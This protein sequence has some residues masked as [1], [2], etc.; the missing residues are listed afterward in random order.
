[1]TLWLKEFIAIKCA[2]KLG[3]FRVTNDIYKIRHGS[4]KEVKKNENSDET[5]YDVKK[6]MEPLPTNWSVLF[7]YKRTCIRVMRKSSREFRNNTVIEIFTITAYGTRNKQL[8]VEMIDEA[9]RMAENKPEKKVKYYQTML[10]YG[11]GAWRLVRRA[12]PRALSSVVLREGVTKAIEE[13][14]ADFLVNKQW[15]SQRGIPYRR[16]YLLYGPPGCGKTSF[17]KAISGKIGYDIYEMQ[18]SDRQL[19]DQ[20]LN[21][22]ITN[23][24]KKG[25]L[26]F[27]DVDAVFTA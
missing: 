11:V 25:I 24:G 21:A 19:T 20:N 2:G 22:L 27:E 16:G 8:L 23:I 14:I 12:Q 7:W 10:D 17:I 18:L 26:L 3:H 6:Q 1:M 4:T 15:Y 5:S 13:D 9:R